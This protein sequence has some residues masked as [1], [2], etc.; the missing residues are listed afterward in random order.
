MKK[1]KKRQFFGARQSLILIILLGISISS[2][3]NRGRLSPAEGTDK[4][5]FTSGAVKQA[6]KVRLLPYWVPSA[7]FAGYYVGIEKGI[8]KKYGIDL[9][10]LPFDPQLT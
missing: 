7:Q 2:C 10:I 9:E 1:H 6:R 3:H 8:F 5:S 4:A